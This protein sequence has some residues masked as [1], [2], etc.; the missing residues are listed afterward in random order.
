MMPAP[1]GN[2]FAIG[3]SGKPKTFKT[4]KELQ[5]AIDKYFD[6]CDSRVVKYF[7]KAKQTVIEIPKPIPYTTEGLC[8]V[9][10]C[11]RQTLLNY[12]KH[13]G[14][15][16]FFDTVMR[17]RLK[18][19]KNKVERAL[20]GDSNPNFSMFDLKNNHG[21]K[22]KRELE[23]SGPDGGPIQVT[24]YEKMTDDQLAE[25]L[26]KLEQIKGE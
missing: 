23:T 15:E 11:S 25:I 20:D 10:G 19:Q 14:Y 17:A 2:K 16:E 5:A 13:P 18:I 1:K 24:G 22:D 8:E 3:N 7:D 6:L 26:N 4:V 21:Y 9:L 12:E